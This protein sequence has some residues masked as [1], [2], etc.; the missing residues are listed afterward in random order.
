MGDLKEAP[1]FGLVQSCCDYLGS[2][3]VDGR[4]LP[5]FQ[6]NQ[7][8][9]F[10]YNKHM[11]RTDM[12]LKTRKSKQFSQ[13]SGVGGIIVVKTSKVCSAHVCKA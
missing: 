11:V 13:G 1:N 10:K 6:I 5:L 9:I 3:S 7:I 8:N 4:S 12:A 2:D